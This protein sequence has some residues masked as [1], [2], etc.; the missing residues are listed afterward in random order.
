MALKNPNPKKP[1]R[2][3]PRTPTPGTQPPAPS[4]AQKVEPSASPAPQ[5]KGDKPSP[6]TLSAAYLTFADNH[7]RA[8]FERVTGLTDNEASFDDA[9]AALLE[10]NSSEPSHPQ[11]QS[12]EFDKLK[13]RLPEPDIRP[14]HF[15]TPLQ[16]MR[17][18]YMRTRGR[19]SPRT[20]ELLDSPVLED[21]LHDLQSIFERSELM[22]VPE[23]A[24]A[25]KI[26]RIMGPQSGPLLRGLSDPRLVEPW[27]LFLDGWDI[28]VPEG[29]DSDVELFLEGEVELDDG[30][31]VEVLQSLAYIEGEVV[32]STHWGDLKDELIFDGE[33][34][35]R[36]RTSKPMPREVH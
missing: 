33:G 22:Q 25:S 32:L 9:V 20:Q 4:R 5:T 1:N 21:L 30:R 31:A 23:A 17:D 28:W 10:P 13:A 6:P 18:I 34:F 2:K 12:F 27:R 26:L 3:P 11:L 35:F 24:V 29:R 7:R 15:L 36:L 8:Q 14:P 16:A 19:A